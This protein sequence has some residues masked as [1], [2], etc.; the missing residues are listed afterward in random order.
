LALAFPCTGAYKGSKNTLISLL[1]HGSKGL[2]VASMGIKLICITMHIFY[3]CS[4]RKVL[5]VN[6]NDSRRTREGKESL[7]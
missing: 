6:V 2:Q 7:R 3:I 5:P 1:A 4:V